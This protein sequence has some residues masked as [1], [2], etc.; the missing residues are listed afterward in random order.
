MPILDQILIYLSVFAFS[1]GV[2]FMH[3]RL[4]NKASLTL[5]I[6]FCCFVAW[7]NL[8]D[9][10]LRKYMGLTPDPAIEAVSPALTSEERAN[11]TAKAFASLSDN[12]TFDEI[13]SIVMLTLMLLFCVAFFL[14][15]R[16][17]RRG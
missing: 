4:R 11:N 5:V 12:Y 9:W 16:S 2:L 3:V 13:S 7:I 6:S 1:V 14:S 17:I 8:K 10:F 15:A